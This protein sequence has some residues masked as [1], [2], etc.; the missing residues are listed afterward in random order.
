MDAAPSST[1]RTPGSRR[2]GPEGVRFCSADNGRTRIAW[3]ECGSGPALIMLPGW[4]CHLQDSWSH[5][6]ALSARRKLAAHHRFIWYDRLGCG[7]SSRR[8]FTLSLENDLAQLL[9]VMDAAGL[10]HASLIGYSM[11]GP[12]AAALAARHPER[13]ERLIFCSAFARGTSVTHADQIRHLQEIVQRNWG[14]G[15]RTLSTMLLPNG[16]SRDVSWLSR[17]QRKAADADTA[18]ALLGHLRDLDVTAQLPDIR[19][20]SLVLHNRQDHA[21]PLAAGEELAALIPGASMHVLAGNEHDPFIRDS[22]DLIPLQL[23]FLAGRPL[24]RTGEPLAAGKPAAP[25][26]RRESQVLQLIVRGDRN[27]EIAAALGIA[28]G[29]V[30]RHITHLYGKLGARG[31]ADAIRQALALGLTAP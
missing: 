10:E 25:L 13:V 6:A 16:S 29:T 20:P 23:D 15:S 24:R 11:G 8:G 30:E 18:A 27:K 1:L 7:L 22:G 9:A 4:L 17:F 2:H 19:A 31:R 26:S 5:P 12:P 28:V 3:A 14:L 21:I